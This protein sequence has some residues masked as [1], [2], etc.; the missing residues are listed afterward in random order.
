MGCFCSQTNI[1]NAK[2]EI[3][4]EVQSAVEGKLKDGCKKLIFGKQNKD[5]KKR[6]VDSTQQE[7]YQESLINTDLEYDPNTNA[8]KSYEPTVEVTTNKT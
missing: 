8:E 6:L 4:Y 3:I 1:D 2:D 7:S 5:A